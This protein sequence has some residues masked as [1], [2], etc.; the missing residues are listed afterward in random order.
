VVEGGQD[1][2]VSFKD[3]KPE[4]EQKSWVFTASGLAG[5]VEWLNKLRKRVQ[6]ESRG[7][8]CIPLGKLF[9][10]PQSDKT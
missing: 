5:E 10:W 9:R 4:H 1:R 3:F 6:I 7:R 8:D 2:L